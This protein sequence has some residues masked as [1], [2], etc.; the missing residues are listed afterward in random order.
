MSE[1][2]SGRELRAAIRSAMVRGGLDPSHLS[3]FERLCADAARQHER[4]RWADAFSRVGAEAINGVELLKG[5]R[6]K[7]AAHT[8]AD[9][10]KSVARHL[11]KNVEP[12][13]Y[14]DAHT[15]DLPHAAD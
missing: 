1:K 12:R 14:I 6:R 9:L 3:D 8:E 4:D 7:A 13:M 11:R 15:E 10:L 5:K 2:L